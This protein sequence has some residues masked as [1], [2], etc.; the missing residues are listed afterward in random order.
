[1]ILNK[2]LDRTFL[3]SILAINHIFTSRLFI[4][5]KGTEK[6]H[7]EECHFTIYSLG[8]TEFIDRLANTNTFKPALRISGLRIYHYLDL[9]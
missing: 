3:Y 7:M 9:Q 2:E 6:T 1:V 4:C 5:P 8:L